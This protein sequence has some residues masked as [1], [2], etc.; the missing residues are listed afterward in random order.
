MSAH[1]QVLVTQALALQGTEQLS[2]SFSSPSKWLTF[3]EASPQFLQ[4]PYTFSWL[5]F[6][7]GQKLFL[8]LSWLNLSFQGSFSIPRAENLIATV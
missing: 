6:D 4:N 3:R 2:L 5:S 1:G 7:R 8:R